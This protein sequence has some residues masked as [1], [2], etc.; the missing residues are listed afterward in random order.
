MTFE[1]GSI[2]K[3]DSYLD[4]NLNGGYLFSDRLTAFA[5]INN[6]FSQKYHTVV[7]YQVQT[8]QILGGI[9]YKFDL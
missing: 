8:V 1:N 4:L 3:N 7:N 5:K 2:V 6:A 9:T